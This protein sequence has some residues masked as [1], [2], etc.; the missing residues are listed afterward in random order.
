ML[1][2]GHVKASSEYRERSGVVR[3]VQAFTQRSHGAL[4]AP[5]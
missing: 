1:T 3:R 5:G 2:F 4:N